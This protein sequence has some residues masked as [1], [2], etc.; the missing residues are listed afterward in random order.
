MHHP[1]AIA[2]E[3]LWRASEARPPTDDT[4]EHPDDGPAPAR[5]RRWPKLRL[6]LAGRRVRQQPL[7]GRPRAVR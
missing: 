5:A 6:R 7:G 4:D 2:F 3:Q 1:Y